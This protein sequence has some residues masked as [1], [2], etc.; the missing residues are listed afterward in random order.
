MD[1]SQ[2]LE[3]YF[4]AN[5]VYF[6]LHSAKKY[7]WE[8][9]SEDNDCTSFYIAGLWRS[10]L[11]WFTW[12][13][14]EQELLITCEYNLKVTSFSWES[15]YK[16]LNLANKKC[17]D[18]HFTYCMKEGSLIYHNKFRGSDA[19]EIGRLRSENILSEMISLMDDLYPAFQLGACGNESSDK[20]IELA[21]NSIV[22]VM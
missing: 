11:G 7:Q 21:G 8:V 6:F 20:A 12:I 16:T 18:G 9:L 5:P 3:N 2:D 17:V 13:D 19:L 10:Y 22:R 14:S 4:S 15:F 1:L